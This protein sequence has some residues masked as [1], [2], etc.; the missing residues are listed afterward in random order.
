MP[1]PIQDKIDT[2]FSKYPHHSYKRGQVLAYANDDI[3]HVYYLVTGE[4][5]QYD[6]TPGGEIVIINIFKPGTFF[7][8]ANAINNTPN[9]YFLEAASSVEVH[10]APPAEA[11]GFIKDNTDVMFDLLRRLYIGVEGVLQRVS[12]LLASSAGTRLVFEIYNATLRFGEKQQ[13]ESWKIKITQSE[14]AH[15]TGLARETVNREFT[16]LKSIGLIESQGTMLIIPSL[17]KIEDT[18]GITQNQ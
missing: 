14:L 11:V 2:F 4:V 15:R 18:L 13:D 9:R 12:H 10:V 5:R 17:P 6:V 16:K 8:M 3:E 1:T 7:P